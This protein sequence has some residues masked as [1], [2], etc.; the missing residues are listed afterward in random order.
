[1]TCFH[2]IHFRRRL[3]RHTGTVRRFLRLFNLPFR[4]YHEEQSGPV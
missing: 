1:M 3:S 2:T 4:S